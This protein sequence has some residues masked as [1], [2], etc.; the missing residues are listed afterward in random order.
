MSAIRCFFIVY[1]SRC[2]HQWQPHEGKPLSS[3]FFLDD[4]KHPNPDIQF[5]KFAITGA[6]YNRELKI[7]S[8]E[9]WNCLQIVSFTAPMDVPSNF[10]VHPCMKVVL[11]LSANYL[12]MSDTKR[13]VLY[14][15]QM[16]QD[17]EQGRAHVSSIAEF[18][19]TQPCLSMA[20]QDAG[21]RRFKKQVSK[22]GTTQFL[23]NFS[24]VL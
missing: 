19:L 24:S 5:W 20:V 14:V 12:V 1:Y 13:V 9:T 23:E 15:L 16:Y 22:M 10:Q 21:R 2:L 17:M 3:L 6:D 8:C 7:W 18:L 4:H 11:D